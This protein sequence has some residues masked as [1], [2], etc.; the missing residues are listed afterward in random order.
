MCVTARDWA[1][2]AAPTKIVPVL[3]APGPGSG[4]IVGEAV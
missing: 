3:R 1:L 4:A 2:R